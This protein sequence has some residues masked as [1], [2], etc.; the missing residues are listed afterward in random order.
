MNM[1]G[2]G[3]NWFHDKLNLTTFLREHAGEKHAAFAALWL[4]H[5]LSPKKV[6]AWMG[7]SQWLRE[8]GNKREW[9]GAAKAA[10]HDF[11]LWRYRLRWGDK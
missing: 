5:P 9:E 1:P 2:E 3:V 7:V 10:F 8:S 11:K 4:S 6:C